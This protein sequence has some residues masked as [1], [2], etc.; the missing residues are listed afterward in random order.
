MLLMVIYRFYISV[1]IKVIIANVD[2]WS[3]LKS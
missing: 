1:K 3:T 2:F